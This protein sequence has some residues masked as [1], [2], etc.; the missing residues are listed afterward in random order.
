MKGKGQSEIQLNCQLKYIKFPSVFCAVIF[1][2]VCRGIAAG[3]KHEP[4]HVPKK[5]SGKG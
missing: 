2:F 5:G 3:L 1:A 4:A